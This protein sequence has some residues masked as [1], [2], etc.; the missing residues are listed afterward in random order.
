MPSMAVSLHR[1]FEVSNYFSAH[2]I[3]LATQPPLSLTNQNLLAN[4]SV[5]A[6]GGISFN[7]QLPNL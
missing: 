2:L 6:K 7:E 1:V 4:A 3:S 5:I